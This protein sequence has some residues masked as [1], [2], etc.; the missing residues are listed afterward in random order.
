MDVA[1]DDSVRNHDPVAA[2]G[3][4]HGLFPLVFVDQVHGPDLVVSWDLGL[5][6]V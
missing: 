1:V 6:K 2:T 5:A 4:L 3:L